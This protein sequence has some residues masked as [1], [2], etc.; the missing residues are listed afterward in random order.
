MESLLEVNK[1]ANSK[2]KKQRLKQLREQ[3]N[4]VTVQRGQVN[5][6]THERVTK[7][8]QETL[9]KQFNKHK[10]HFQDTLMQP[11]GNAFYFFDSTTIVR[12]IKADPSQSIQP[13]A[14]PKKR[15]E[16][17][18]ADKGSAQANKLVSEAVKY[19]RLSK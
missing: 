11:P 13:N 6:S 10:R 16:V 3:G 1:M 8:K 5:F 15:T 9:N 17:P 2:A 4:D 12:R 7:T 14:T 18:A 19:F